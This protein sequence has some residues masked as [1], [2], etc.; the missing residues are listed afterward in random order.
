MCNSVNFKSL[1]S[2]LLGRENRLAFSF[3]TE[4]LNLRHVIIETIFSLLS[5]Y[6]ISTS[7]ISLLNESSRLPKITFKVF[8]IL[9]RGGGGGGQTKPWGLYQIEL[10]RH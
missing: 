6:M 7:I 8:C 4:L 1:E 9:R 5:I 2:K 10:T 3:R